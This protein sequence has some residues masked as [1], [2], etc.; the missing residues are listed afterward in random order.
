[1]TEL[2][3]SRTTTARPFDRLARAATLAAALGA[4]A[5]ANNVKPE[6]LPQFRITDVN[7]ITAPGLKASSDIASA[8]RAQTRR[9]A[10]AYA[11]PLPA[12]L[13]GRTLNV[14][15]TSVAYKN[16]VASLLVGSANRASATVSGGAAGPGTV[17]YTDVS[18]GAVNG[19][20]GAVMAANADHARVDGKLAAGLGL[21]AVDQAYGQKTT[22]RFVL[23][24]L[25]PR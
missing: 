2:A 15:V 24:R 13:P 8:V 10:A 18:S 22:P 14:R 12:N 16:A 5:C 20:I 19:V 9:A 7:V 11:A 23:D 3:L 6:E 4:T 21:K 1:M 25:G 17:T